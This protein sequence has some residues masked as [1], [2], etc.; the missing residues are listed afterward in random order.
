M[1]KK[2]SRVYEQREVVYREDRWKILKGL[3]E[4]AT[5][6]MVTLESKGVES[7][8]HGSLARGDVNSKSD[9]DIFA[10]ETNPSYLIETAITSGGFEISRRELEQATPANVIK[11]LIYINEKVKI[12][13][14]LLPLRGKER[15]FYRFGGE[16]GLKKLREGARVPGVDKRLMMIIPTEYGH[17]EYSIIDNSE[18]AARVIGVS[19]ELVKERIRVLTRRDD[20]GRTGVYYEEELQDDESFESKLRDRISRDPSLKRLFQRRGLGFKY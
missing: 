18:E 13:F 5:S 7:I 10:P 15:D 2:V 11:A 17:H 14:P 6:I 3:R 12:S 9:I 1:A 20:I 19:Q 4:V 16:I 8:V